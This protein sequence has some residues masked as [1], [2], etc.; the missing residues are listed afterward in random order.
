MVPCCS[1]GRVQRALDSGRYF[2]ACAGRLW[3]PSLHDRALPALG[4][5]PTSTIKTYAKADLDGSH[6]APWKLHPH[7]LHLVAL[8]E[9][10]LATSVCPDLRVDAP[11][12]TLAVGHRTFHCDSGVNVTVL[13]QRLTLATSRGVGIQDVRRSLVGL[14]HLLPCLT[15]AL[16]TG[17]FRLPRLKRREV[18]RQSLETVLDHV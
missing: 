12:V 13:S 1:R 3:E 5:L 9:A 4:A 2:R 16:A 6:A 17:V 11:Q 14:S 7:L 18:G 15:V 10:S 8:R